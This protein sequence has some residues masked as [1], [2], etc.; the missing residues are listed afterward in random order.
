MQEGPV[1]SPSVQAPLLF[2]TLCVNI[3]LNMARECVTAE[4]DFLY[5]GIY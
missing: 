1:G 5:L 4:F 3:A 2:T